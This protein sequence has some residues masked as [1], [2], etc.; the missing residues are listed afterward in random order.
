[1]DKGMYEMIPINPNTVGI[2]IKTLISLD[3]TLLLEDIH[4]RYAP[5]M[6]KLWV[7][8]KS[9]MHRMIVIHA[10]MTRSRNE[11]LLFL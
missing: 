4:R 9:G 7:P 3:M 1:M 8:T 6:S 10:N 11:N 2:P 5:S